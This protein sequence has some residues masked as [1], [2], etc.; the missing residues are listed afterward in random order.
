[1]PRASLFAQ[2]LLYGRKHLLRKPE[3]I[4]R[5]TSDARKN[6]RAL[7]QKQRSGSRETVPKDKIPVF[8]ASETPARSRPV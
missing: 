8:I 7:T 4:I 3:R 2:T 1:M 5:G 6:R